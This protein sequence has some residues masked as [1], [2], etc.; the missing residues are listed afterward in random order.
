MVTLHGTTR[1]QFTPRHAD[2]RPVVTNTS[3]LEHG[4]SKYTID[5]SDSQAVQSYCSMDF[6]HSILEKAL[7]SFLFHNEFKETMRSCNVAA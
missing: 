6:A 7:I 4:H 2:E 3:N 5:A 1:S